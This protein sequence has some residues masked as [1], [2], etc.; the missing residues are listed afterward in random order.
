[1]RAAAPSAGRAP[2]SSRREG[3]LDALR[4][5]AAL[6]VVFDHL[7]QV[8]LRSIRPAVYGWIE[9]GRYGVFLFFLV[10]GYIIPASLEHKGSVRM[11]WVSRVFRLFP[12]YL[13]TISLVVLLSAVGQESLRGAESD[14]VNSVLAQLL[15]MSD[16][17]AGPNVPNVVW[18]LTYE[19]TFYL[20]VT[21]LFVT[22]VHRY[23]GWLAAGFG[24][25]AVAL[26]G[27]LPR[28]YLSGHVTG[29]A[30]VS[31]VAGLLLAG[32]VLG[33][34]F[35]RGPARVASAALA[36]AVAL[37]LTGVNSHP[38]GPGPGSTPF[39]YTFEIP[40]ILALMFT[41]TALYRAVQ[42]QYTW[43]RAA[44]AVG[45]ALGLCAAAALLHMRTHGMGQGT[46]RYL[47]RRWLIGFGAAFGTFMAG[48]ALRHRRMPAA[49]TWLGLISY[50]VYLL[51]PVFR[52][53]LYN[54]LF[55]GHLT[56]GR[57]VYPSYPAW[58]Q[59]LIGLLTVAAV[60]A[61]AS[62]TYLL[63]ERPAQHLARR[64]GPRRPG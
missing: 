2:S 45:C 19:M 29:P 42:G 26:G 7:S 14:P 35:L 43:L 15:M 47:E 57:W 48:L 53:V 52:D 33:A 58:L 4:G 22:G 62:V 60:I 51:H 21:F 61:A 31:A 18:S 40:A 28:L 30:V 25:C 10:S 8:T 64:C 16:A 5:I 37:T 36:A 63:V 1:V 54:E 34:V 38:A 46:T 56:G 59:S 39:P 13:V 9:P 20:L 50:S 41:G 27:V 6:A 44:I 32:G 12:M 24:V 17:L 23:S 3:W 11:F 49:L 55:A